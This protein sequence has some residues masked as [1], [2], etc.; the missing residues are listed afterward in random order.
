MQNFEERR[1]IN[2]VHLRVRYMCKCKSFS[3][4]FYIQERCHWALLL[5]S[6]YFMLHLLLSNGIWYIPASWKVLVI[7]KKT[8]CNNWYSV[9]V[10]FQIW[11]VCDGAWMIRRD[12]VSAYITAISRLSTDQQDYRVICVALTQLWEWLWLICRKCLVVTC[13][14]AVSL[15]L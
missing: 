7:I 8:T 10:I 2:C 11:C 14:L 15:F 4:S 12:Q 1:M 5:K 13:P 9:I 6:A 3:W